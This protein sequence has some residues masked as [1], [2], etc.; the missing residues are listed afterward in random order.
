M[1]IRGNPDHPVTRGFLCAKVTRYLDREYH[2]ERL[3]FPM[4]RVGPKGEGRFERISWEA[5][6]D[7]IAS[8]LTQIAEKYGSEAIL[9]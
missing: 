5:A 6:L 1:R 3:R 8:R 9:P 2:P 4:R 7:E